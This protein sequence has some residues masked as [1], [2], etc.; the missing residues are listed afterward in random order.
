MIGDSRTELQ[1]ISIPL[2]SQHGVSKCPCLRII[3]THN[4][5]VPVG[6]S[7]VLSLS[8]YSMALQVVQAVAGVTSVNAASA[9]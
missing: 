9:T 2:T 1:K 8:Q 7:A 6:P 4:V 3:R 5:H